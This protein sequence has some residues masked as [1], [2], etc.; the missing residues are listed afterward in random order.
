MTGVFLW[1]ALV[2]T[3]FLVHFNQAFI[4]TKSFFLKI[5]KSLQE[6]TYARVFLL[7]E[8]ILH[9]PCN[10]IKKRLQ[11]RYYT[12]NFAKSLK[13]SSRTP[14]VNASA[15]SATFIICKPFILTFIKIVEIKAVCSK[16][17]F[18]LLLWYSFLLV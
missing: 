3:V 14:P 2:N 12:V 7:D 11:R 9:Q 15:A 16:D 10:F 8:V 18:N 17:S 13:V 5:S 1:I 6:N 4:F